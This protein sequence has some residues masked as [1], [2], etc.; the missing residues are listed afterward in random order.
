MSPRDK[1]ES[2]LA[3]VASG[4]IGW[5]LHGSVHRYH[6][7][8][9][10]A[11]RRP[12]SREERAAIIAM[13]STGQLRIVDGVGQGKR[14]GSLEPTPGW[15]PPKPPAACVMCGRERTAV[16][17]DYNP[18]QVVTGQPCGWYSGSDG[19]ICGTD[20]DILLARQNSGRD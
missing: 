20:M 9:T 2:V 6:V 16:D 19:E 11:S 10:D 13:L 7:W 5:V 17:V 1:R 3:L 15:V 8:V 18:L 14:R 4:D 12:V